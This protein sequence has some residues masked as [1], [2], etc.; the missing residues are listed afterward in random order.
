MPMATRDFLTGLTVSAVDAWPILPLASDSPIAPGR[1]HNTATEETRWNFGHPLRIKLL[2]SL[3]ME[4]FQEHGMAAHRSALPTLTLT[5]QDDRHLA[6]EVDSFS[7]GWGIEV[8]LGQVAYSENGTNKHLTQKIQLESY[9]SFGSSLPYFG[10]GYRRLLD[11]AGPDVNRAGIPEIDRLSELSYAVIG[12][13]WKVDG[14][15][16][17]RLQFNH[18]LAGR[19]TDYFSQIIGS[20]DLKTRQDEGYGL[21]ISFNNPTGWAAFARLWRLGESTPSSFVFAGGE[22]VSRTTPKNRSVEVG[23]RRLLN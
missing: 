18:L 8:S 16:M 5:L 4:Q 17:L 14:E 15:S 20:N 23:I 3:S 6:N 7:M 11:D 2:A 12:R 13:A 22:S 1:P 9:S 19:Q 21:E 10:I